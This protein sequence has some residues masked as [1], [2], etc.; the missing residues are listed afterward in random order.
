MKPLTASAKNELNISEPKECPDIAI[1]PSGVDHEA[2]CDWY[3]MDFFIEWRVGEECDGYRESCQD[4]QYLDDDS[5]RALETRARMFSYAARLLNH[6]HRLF[7]FAVDIYGDRARLYR[8]DP[9]CIIV[10]DFIRFR[11]D[12]QPLDDFFSRYSA[13]SPAQRGYDPTVTC[14]TETEK[15]LFRSCIREYFVRTRGNDLREH[16]GVGVLSGKI[17]KVQV[18]DINGG[19]HWYLACKCATIPA[20]LLPCGRFTRGFIATTASSSATLP[21]TQRAHTRKR[22]QPLS[23]NGRLFWLKDCWR[24]DSVESEASV[25]YGLKARGVPNLPNI[26]CAG[27]VLVGATLQET[28]NDALLSD[29]NTNSWRR[30]TGH[31]HHMIHHRI[32]AE[33]LIPLNGVENARELL[34]VGRD[35]L[36]SEFTSRSPAALVKLLIAI[37]TAFHKGSMY[38]RDV[39]KGNVM[40]TERRGND[41]GPWGILND[42]DRAVRTDANLSGRTVSKYVS[43]LDVSLIYVLLQ[44][45]W[46]TMSISLLGNLHKPHDIFDD[47]ESLLWV[48]LFFAIRHFKYSGKFDMRVFNQAQPISDEDGEIQSVGGDSKF[49]WLQMPETVF[50]CK[51]LQDFFDSFRQFHLDYISK[52]SFSKAGGKRK[53]TFQ[54]FEAEVL[55]DVSSLASHF[56]D[57]LNDPTVDWTG[58]EA[59]DISPG[60]QRNRKENPDEELDDENNLHPLPHVK[61]PQ[62]KECKDSKKRKREEPQADKGRQRKRTQAAVD[63]DNESHGT[64]EAIARA[65]RRRRDP[66]APSTRVL[67]PRTR[68]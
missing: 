30:P 68:K 27:D 50:D 52:K 23:E 67:R 47:L 10:S 44:G 16:P 54:E 26:R 31:I 12:P 7:L 34:L 51:P 59:H 22:G 33:L 46:Q 29:R 8:F 39:S 20:N 58:Q 13:L 53:A 11:K 3:L 41:E 9:S 65:P 42:W 63:K 6:Q 36:N 56:N 25:Y 24:P 37:A 32:V 21:G 45:T 5:D 28:I 61:V 40:M 57:V 55:R 60:N 62:P 49:L 2:L 66:P 43:F 14:A 38:H 18:N 35:V 1:Y 4:D 48:L 19:I 64:E 17:F 15:T